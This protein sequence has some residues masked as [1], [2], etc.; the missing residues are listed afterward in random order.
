VFV[1]PKDFFLGAGISNRERSAMNSDSIKLVC[2]PALGA[3]ASNALQTFAQSLRHGFS[4]GL[5]REF[6]QGSSKI[7]CLLVA[8]V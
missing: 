4:L 1:K 2:K 3:R 5:S 6:C 7:F 8:N